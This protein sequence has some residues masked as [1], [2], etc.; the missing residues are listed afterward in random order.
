M[1]RFISWAMNGPSSWFW[2]VR[3]VKRYRRLLWPVITV[4]SCR[5]QWPPSSHTGQ[6][7]GWLVIS[8]ST[9]LSRKRLASSSS[10][11]IQVLSLAGVMQDMTMRPRVSFSSVYCFTAHWRQAPT[12][13][14]AGCQQK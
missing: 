2:W 11:E 5:W 13:P 1:Q 12:L 10:M 3:L 7:C 6:S 4:M 8:H 14:S 9:T